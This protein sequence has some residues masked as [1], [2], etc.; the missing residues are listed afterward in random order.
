MK[1]RSCSVFLQSSTC[2][3]HIF[4]NSA[5]NAHKWQFWFQENHWDWK[6]SVVGARNYRHPARLVAES[7]TTVIKKSFFKIEPK[8]TQSCFF[9]LH[10]DPADVCMLNLAPISLKFIICSIA[11]CMSFTNE[12]FPQCNDIRCLGHSQSMLIRKNCK[13]QK[14][15]GSSVN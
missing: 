14:K 3:V 9:Q 12:F 6:L 8:K 1:A 15:S 7:L 13:V 4:R 2:H 11:S 5:R 10:E